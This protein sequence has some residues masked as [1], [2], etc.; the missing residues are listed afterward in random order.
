[1]LKVFCNEAI[2]SKRMQGSLRGVARTSN[3]QQNRNRGWE[4]KG[5]F[6]ESLGLLGKPAAMQ[7][8]L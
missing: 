1:M 3:T 8:H 6:G 2:E 7:P 5:E 4:D